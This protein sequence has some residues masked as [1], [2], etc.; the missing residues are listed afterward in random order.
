MEIKNK[1]IKGFESDV[2]YKLLFISKVRVY[3]KLLRARNTTINH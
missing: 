2:Y 1:S 3:H